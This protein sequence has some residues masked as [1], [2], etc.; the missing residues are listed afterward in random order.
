MT[1]AVQEACLNVRESLE[2][3]VC[4]LGRLALSWR[5]METGLLGGKGEGAHEDKSWI[6]G[7]SLRTFL[8]DLVRFLCSHTAIISYSYTAEPGTE[9]G[10]LS[11]SQRVES[12]ATR[13]QLLHYSE[14]PLH[15]TACTQLTDV[16][17]S[18]FNNSALVSCHYF[19][20]NSGCHA[21][22]H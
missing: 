14:L 11:G 13:E 15:P 5:V 12:T 20:S 17:S 21:G 19:P 22:E 4:L 7:D 1:D 10:L 3:V 9:S 2:H 18:G 6:V 8:S 16:R